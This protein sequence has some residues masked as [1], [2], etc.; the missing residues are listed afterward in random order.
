MKYILSNITW[1]NEGKI[2]KG[3]IT[4]QEGKIHKIYGEGETHFP[5]G[6]E[7]IDRTGFYLFPGIID[8]HVHFRE[9]GLTHKADIFSESRAAAAGGVTSFLEM[10]NTNPQTTTI[11]ALNEKKAIAQ[12]QSLIN[13][14]F[15]VGA[16]MDNLEELAKINP[17][18]IPGI[19]VF[20]GSS[21]GNMLL[22]GEKV[23]QLFKALGHLPLVAHCEDEEIIQRNTTLF[24][25]RYPDGGFAALHPQIR[26]EEACYKSTAEAI[27]LASKTNARL[28]IAHLSTA[29]ELSLLSTQNLSGKRITAEVCVN[30]LWF[31]QDDY[32]KYG[33]LI[34]CNPAI[35]TEQDRDAL[36]KA[37]S[38]NALDTVGTDHAPHTFEE[39]QKPFFEAPSG[40][41]FIQFSLNC[42][43]ELHQKGLISLETLV[44]KMCHNPAILFGIKDRGFIREG[45]AADMVLVDLTKSTSV[46]KETIYSKCKWSPLEGYIF[47]NSVEETIVN[48]E[49]V[50]R[51]NEF[52]TSQSGQELRFDH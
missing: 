37:L 19:K 33:N 18:E 42:M 28:H 22:Q 52:F 38:E 2:N 43:L 1:V 8:S 13:Y 7:I 5:E 24:K 40:I 27:E 45:Y 12:K 14:G 32:G 11:Q 26:T 15:F 17:S 20:L 30:H 23:E 25:S 48:G 6:F 36:R 41:P 3:S 46:E 16:T 9:P 31:C 49:F 47:Q 4:V 29:K 35:K 10:P 39:K 34:K 50:Y 51:K 21:T 44:E